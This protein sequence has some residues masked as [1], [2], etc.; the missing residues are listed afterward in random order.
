MIES[1]AGIID[2]REV[3]IE[4]EAEVSNEEKIDERGREGT[5]IEEGMMIGNE[6]SVVIGPAVDLFREV[7]YQRRHPCHRVLLLETVLSEGIIEIVRVGANE[8][9]K[10]NPI[11]KNGGSRQ[12]DIVQGGNGLNLFSSSTAGVDGGIK[13]V[14]SELSPSVQHGRNEEEANGMKGSQLDSSNCQVPQ[15]FVPPQLSQLAQ[16]GRKEDRGNRYPK[17]PPRFSDNS[18]IDELIQL[19]QDNLDV[20]SPMATATQWNKISRQMSK[21]DGRNHNQHGAR[22][23]DSGQNARKIDDIFQHT[24]D[25]LGEFNMMELSQTIFSLS[26]IAAALRKQRNSRGEADYRRVL[27]ELLQKKNMTPNE[28]VF[29]F[30]ADAS[31]GKLNQFDARGLSNLAYAYALIRYVP[32]FDDG[33]DLFDRIATEAVD[34]KGYFIAQGIS[35]MVW[36]YATVNKPHGVFFEAMGDQ[37]VSLQHLKEF[38]PQALSNTM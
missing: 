5:D 24:I 4:V 31:M 11:G 37:I 34:V 14:P 22:K 28:D 35:N 27:R 13:V 33:S 8:G 32:K 7:A 25:R 19:G 29:K 9:T 3:V 15:K 23:G 6:K 1:A 36:A 26:K 38:N 10:V 12:N 17:T 30:F 21:R 2:E 18:T 16:H 20:M